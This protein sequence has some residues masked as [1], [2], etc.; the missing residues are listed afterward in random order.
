MS[1][2]FWLWWLQPF[3]FHMMDRLYHSPLYPFT[4]LM[5]LIQWLQTIAYPPLV[6]CVFPL[7][8]IGCFVIAFGRWLYPTGQ[9]LGWVYVLSLLTAPLLDVV[10][11][12]SERQLATIAGIFAPTLYS[13][14]L[15]LVGAIRALNLPS[16]IRNGRGGSDRGLQIRWCNLVVGWLVAVLAVFWASQLGYGLVCCS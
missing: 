4:R 9:T 16:G 5:E 1:V 8:I 6:S 11:E 2:S 3:G 10:L 7:L 12:V 14:L 15:L 13:L